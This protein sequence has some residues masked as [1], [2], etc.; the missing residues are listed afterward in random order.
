M[1]HM[2]NSLLVLCL[3][4]TAS[5]AVTAQEE[6]SIFGSVEQAITSAEPDYRLDQKKVNEGM[7][8]YTWKSAKSYLIILITTRPTPGHTRMDFE[9][10]PQV[11][12]EHGG[13]NVRVLGEKV[14]GLGDD[15]YM[16]VV[17]G[18]RE[19]MLAFRKGVYHVRI[20]SPSLSHAKRVAWNIVGL[21]PAA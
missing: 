14:A 11:T 6:K 15:N 13:F 7:A 9:S 8:F 18:S 4:F 12:R 19:K 3:I 5:V 10:E 2:R 1:D 17:R 21:F 16:W 20:Y